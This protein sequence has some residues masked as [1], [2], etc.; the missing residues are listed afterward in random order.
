MPTRSRKIPSYRFHRPIG[1]AVIRLDGRD[2]LLGKHGTPASREEHDR[3]VA[4]WL[5]AGRSLGAA[6]GRTGGPP[7]VSIGE[8]ILA[9][10]RHAEQHYRTPDGARLS[11]T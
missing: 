6:R 5:A 8:L 2:R 3:L 10:W 1:Q 9:Y 7:G 4:E 11:E